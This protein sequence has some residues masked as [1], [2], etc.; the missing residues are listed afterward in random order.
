MFLCSNIIWDKANVFNFSQQKDFIQTVRN[1]YG[2]KIAFYFL[3]INHYVLWLTFPT[4]VGII[5]FITKLYK[6]DLSTVNQT[7]HLS[8]F[9]IIFTVFS[10]ILILWVTLFLK[11]WKQKERLYSY[12]WGTENFQ[13]EE[14][15][16]DKFESD[17]TNEFLF[18]FRM[19]FQ[20]RSK[21]FMKKIISYIIV[22]VFVNIS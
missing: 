8:T 1:F 22:L 14:A 11:V 4:F 19:K 18:N 6:S 21:K 3:F 9:N 10:C 2:E 20:K 17:Y 7:F 13:L 5:V 12:F 15:F 16:D